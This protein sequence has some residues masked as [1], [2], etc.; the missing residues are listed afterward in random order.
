MLYGSPCATGLAADV[1]RH[2]GHR[3]SLA[4]AII[5]L[6]IEAYRAPL[7]AYDEALDDLWGDEA[8]TAV[9][10]HLRGHL[11]GAAASGRLAHQAPV[12]YRILPQILG[13]AQRAVGAVVRAA[14]AALG[15]VR[16]NRA[17]VPADD[18]YPSGRVLSNGGFHN[19]AAAP[20]MDWLTAAWAD[21]ALVAQRQVIAMHS[22]TSGLPHLLSPAGFVGGASRGGPHPFR[23]G[24]GGAAQG[25]PGPGP[26]H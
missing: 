17:Y 2:A 3:L 7:D 4:E 16:E 23:P 8:E 18:R 6:S 1:A 19:G 26:P 5:A 24:G 20:A 12:S 10:R 15:L 22:P 13:Q 14:T 21:L 25:G 9:L 11:S